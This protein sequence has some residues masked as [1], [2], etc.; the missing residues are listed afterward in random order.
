MQNAPAR[1]RRSARS[2]D[3]P[4]YLLFFTV[5]FEVEPKIPGFVTVVVV[6]YVGFENTCFCS[7]VTTEVV[8]LPLVSAEDET[9]VLLGIVMICR[10][11]RGA[12]V[13]SGGRGGR[14]KRGGRGGGAA[15]RRRRV[16]RRFTGVLCCVGMGWVGMLAAGGGEQP[17]R[18]AHA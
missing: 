13:V 9:M 2:D 14:A 7:V 15:K 18:V 10:R 3:G 11:R 17:V 16:A 1:T 5:D 12:C 8:T 6:S 4:F